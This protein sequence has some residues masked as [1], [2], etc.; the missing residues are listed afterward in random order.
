MAKLQNRPDNLPKYIPTKWVNDSTALNETHMNNIEDGIVKAIGAVQ[1]LILDMN[2]INN[3]L[4]DLDK[5]QDSTSNDIEYLKED[6]KSLE[7]FVYGITD[8]EQAQ[9]KEE[10]GGKTLHERV[11]ENANGISTNA[12]NISANANS[13]EDNKT[14]IDSLKN[15][16]YGATDPETGESTEGLK[17]KIDKN[18]ADI[19]DIKN[20]IQ[21]IELVDS[22][23]VDG[24]PRS[25]GWTGVRIKSKQLTKNTAACSVN[26]YNLEFLDSNSFVLGYI[27]NDGNLKPY[28]TN[29]LPVRLVGRR[30]DAATVSM[31]TLDITP[32]DDSLTLKPYCYTASS[33]DMAGNI[34]THSFDD[35]DLFEYVEDIYYSGIRGN[36]PYIARMQLNKQIVLMSTQKLS[37]VE[38]ST[39]SLNKP[40]TAVATN[41][42]DS[43]FQ[44]NLTD[45][46]GT[47]DPPSPNS[48]NNWFMFNPNYALATGDINTVNNIGT[49][50]VDLEQDYSVNYIS[51][52]TYIFNSSNVDF[53]N[54]TSC[55]VYTSDDG[56]TFNQ[57]RYLN[58]GNEGP[59]TNSANIMFTGGTV[60]ARYVKFDIKCGDKPVLINNIRIM[61]TEVSDDN[62]YYNIC[63][64]ASIDDG[65]GNKWYAGRIF[66]GINILD[67]TEEKV[68]E[69]YD[70]D[71]N[72]ISKG[73]LGGFCGVMYEDLGGDEISGFSGKVH[74]FFTEDVIELVQYVTEMS[75]LDRVFARLS[76]ISNHE[77]SPYATYEANTTGVYVSDKD[78]ANN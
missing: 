75:V 8:E 74:I 11:K 24:C 61:G 29:F 18:S 59:I 49:I 31:A 21:N 57:F 26:S 5:N 72:V 53:G 58:F 34:I 41:A 33:N 66:D 20:E 62:N 3:E 7:S 67:T 56:E 46:S 39:V 44:A 15:E 78:Y 69:I 27:T 43:I 6:I 19:Q 42:Y 12:D 25:S 54:I 48:P 23:W 13:I 64:T 22:D 51:L 16:I 36:I 47:D 4:G 30:D 35:G 14:E 38:S 10:A 73:A 71:N 63:K 76:V 2:S 1:S 32:F 77:L 28:G 52:N 40:Y 50:I 60:N 65:V 68:G 70:D 17:D 9:S 45:F 55:T 37:S